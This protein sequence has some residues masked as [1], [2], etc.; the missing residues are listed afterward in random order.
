MSLTQKRACHAVKFCQKSIIG[1]G[2]SRLTWD[3]TPLGAFQILQKINSIWDAKNITFRIQQK[4]VEDSLRIF[5]IM[6][7]I[8]NVCQERFPNVT[9]KLVL[10]VCL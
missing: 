3:Y 1:L 4:Y 6:P 8:Q 9:K 5:T 2:P 7:K 10:Y